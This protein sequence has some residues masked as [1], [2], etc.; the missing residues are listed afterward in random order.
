MTNKNF[1]PELIRKKVDWMRIIRPAQVTGDFYMNSYYREIVTYLKLN[2]LKTTPTLWRDPDRHIAI[3]VFKKYVAIEFEGKHFRTPQNFEYVLKFFRWLNSISDPGEKKPWHISRLDICYDHLNVT[4]DY[5]IPDC[6]REYKACFGSK[7]QAIFNPRTEI[8]ETVYL[9]SQKYSLRSYRKD[10][11]I[12][13]HDRRSRKAIYDLS[14]ERY[15]GKA[16]A[17]FEAELAGP[18]VLQHANDILNLDVSIYEDEFV[19]SVM[20]TFLSNKNIRERTENDSN[21]QRWPLY[22]GFEYLKGGTKLEDL[23]VAEFLKL[24]TS[25]D[26]LLRF[27]RTFLNR[28]EKENI[29]EDT[30]KKIIEAELE[31]RKFELETINSLKKSA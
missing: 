26:W 3:S 27:L 9:R 29:S 31:R 1:Q 5:F 20:H 18:E 12:T 16:I 14:D 6:S 28:A 7:Y 25:Q 2:L 4:P 24:P 17:R 10:V 21:E 11:E 30:L 22:P 19:D 15:K 13:T 8:L 23:P